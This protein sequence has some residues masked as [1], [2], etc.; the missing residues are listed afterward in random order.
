MC[1][2]KKKLC[3]IFQQDMEKN[4]INFTSIPMLSWLGVVKKFFFTI[5]PLY[6]NII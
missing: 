2:F 3:N 6:Y 5:L 4:V 1:L